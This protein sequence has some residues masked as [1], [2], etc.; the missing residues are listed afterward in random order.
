MSELSDENSKRKAI[1]D[2]FDGKVSQLGWL[3]IVLGLPLLMVFGLGLLL[4]AFGIYLLLRHKTLTSDSRIDQWTNE[5][6]EK[7][8]FVK[9]AKQ[10]CGF[11][12]LVRD[13]IILRG[14]GYSGASEGLIHGERYGEDGHMRYTPLGATVLLCTQDQLGIYQTAVDLTTGNCANEKVLEVFY[15]DIVAISTQASSESLDT[16]NILQEIKSTSLKP[17]AIRQGLSQKKLMKNIT[18]LTERFREFIIADILQRDIRKTYYIELSDGKTI[19]IPMADG[20][21]TG[22]ANQE[23]DAASGDETARAMVA[24]RKFVREKKRA[25]LHSRPSSTGP[26]V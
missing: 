4:I 12:D 16:K 22:K 26:L 15:Q 6:F 5:D 18:L 24:L 10:L 14:L 17:D 25:V 8:D 19:V 20:R 7:H 1:R 11:E 13:A 2:Y 3:L 9:R 23:D 21:P